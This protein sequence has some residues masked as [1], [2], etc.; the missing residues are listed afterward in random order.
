[1]HAGLYAARTGP[2]WLLV[3]GPEGALPDFNNDTVLSLISSGLQYA[4]GLGD[5]YASSNIEVSHVSNWTY[6][7][8]TQATI[9]SQCPPRQLGQLFQQNS[10]P[11]QGPNDIRVVLQFEFA[12]STGLPAG[13]KL[14]S[15]MGDRATTASLTQRLTDGG[16]LPSAQPNTVYVNL[17]TATSASAAAS[18]LQ[19]YTHELQRY[20]VP[21]GRCRCLL[22]QSHR[23]TSG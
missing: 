18:L 19:G 12:T 23:E 20:M 16:F 21:I 3:S 22:G 2:Y 10:G 6:D 13:W 1:M 11:P 8:T 4:L 7:P 14:R 9:S 5:A 17:T 15:K